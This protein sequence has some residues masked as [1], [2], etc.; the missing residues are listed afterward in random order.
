MQI[1]VV[2]N[3]KPTLNRYQGWEKIAMKKKKLPVSY[4]Q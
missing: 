3:A 1:Q 2:L 4:D